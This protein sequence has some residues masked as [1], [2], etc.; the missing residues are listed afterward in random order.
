[1][2]PDHVY[3]NVQI[4]NGT[5]AS[6]NPYC[7]FQ[8]TRTTPIIDNPSDYHLSVVRFQI[9]TMDVPLSIIPARI[10]Q[11][12]PDHTIYTV[13][14]QKTVDGV[15][16]KATAPVL[17]SPESQSQPRPAPPVSRQDVTSS[18]Y[19][20]YSYGHF[21]DLLNTAFSS[22]LESL[23]S[24]L[25]VDSQLPKAP[26]LEYDPS[27][28]TFSLY[29]TSSYNSQ[30]VDSAS[31]YMNAALYYLFPNFMSY[32]LQQSPFADSEQWYQYRIES[33]PSGT[34]STSDGYYQMR[35]EFP[36]LQTWTAL[37]TLVLTTTKPSAE[38]HDVCGY[39]QLET[40]TT[41]GTKFC[42]S[43]EEAGAFCTYCGD[44]AFCPKCEGAAR[45][46]GRLMESEWFSDVCKPCLE[47]FMVD[48]ADDVKETREEMEQLREELEARTAKLAELEASLPRREAKLSL[49]EREVQQMRDAAAN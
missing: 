3:M 17:W 42:W 30:L 18:Y 20:L 39:T 31:I 22:A 8:E 16:Y 40:C 28:Y 29:A 21:V 36:N 47:G 11:D 33:N 26:F 48:A 12:N 32:Q 25:P 23:N 6:S 43:C 14:L 34:N 35:Q 4:A 24:Q 44:P 27:S 5:A 45:A 15:T 2:T 7:R 37:N 9:S 41:C 10:G 19:W 49:L 1:M 38:L 13:G 46:D